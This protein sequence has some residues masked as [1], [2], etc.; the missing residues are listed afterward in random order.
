MNTCKVSA[1]LQHM[2][3]GVTAPKQWKLI[4]EKKA[5][6][7]GRRF[8]TVY[9]TE[10]RK[11]NVKTVFLFICC[12]VDLCVPCGVHYRTR[13]GGLHFKVRKSQGRSFNE[14]GQ[15]AQELIIGHEDGDPVT[16]KTGSKDVSYE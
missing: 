10:H 7:I 16:F 13:N 15:E 1:G 12:K 5:T 11:W 2:G 3:L 9:Y 8:S 14:K 6:I 4:E